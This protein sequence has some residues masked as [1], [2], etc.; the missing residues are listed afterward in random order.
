M[1]EIPGDLLRRHV[2]EAI[3]SLRGR[4]RRALDDNEHGRTL[5]AGALERAVVAGFGAWSAIEAGP[6]RPWPKSE[7]ETWTRWQHQRQLTPEALRWPERL[8]HADDPRAAETLE[9][10]VAGALEAGAELGLTGAIGGRGARRALTDLARQ[11]A[12]AG[13]A[14]RCGLEGDLPDPPPLP[15]REEPALN[16]SLGKDTVQV[17]VASNLP[18]CELIQ[19]VLANA[20]IE[21]MWT[22]T[23]DLPEFLAGGP[24][25]I[26]VRAAAG[27]DARRALAP[28]VDPDEG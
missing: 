23:V 11:A 18:E 4:T 20:G 26:H 10:A 7:D 21:S 8:A 9:R 13:A 17:A 28:V 6:G 16:R 5:I 2:D 3:D 14:L 1:S 24:R 25:A 22:R 12:E 27:E 19:G 15:A